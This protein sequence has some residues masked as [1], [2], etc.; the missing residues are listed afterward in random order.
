M[1]SAPT[2]GA[3]TPIQ[4]MPSSTVPSSWRKR[5]PTDIGLLW[6]G[7]MAGDEH[8]IGRDGVDHVDSVAGRDRLVGGDGVE[9]EEAVVRGQVDLAGAGTA[10]R[11]G[12]VDL[13]LLS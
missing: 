6:K 2:T 10:T 8:G 1:A 9:F 3:T 4:L 7:R 13:R 5:L 12:E 11:H